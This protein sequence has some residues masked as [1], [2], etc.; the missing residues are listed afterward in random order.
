MKRLGKFFRR[1]PAERRLF[2]TASLLLAVV[3]LSLWLRGYPATARLLAR[4]EK[5]GRGAAATAE[6]IRWA[7]ATA[8]AYVPGGTCLVQAMAGSLLCRRAGIAADVC[9]GVGHD[10]ERGFEAHA[11]LE[12]DGRILLGEDESERFTPLTT[13][14]EKP[15]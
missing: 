3:R 9:I 15:L 1:P 8:A 6:Q 7:V 2:L 13:L 14:G 11:W 12:S 5:P 10:P 4:L